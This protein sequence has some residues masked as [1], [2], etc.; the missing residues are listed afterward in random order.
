MKMS[1]LSIF[2]FIVRVT[3][4]ESPREDKKN[5]TFPD[6]EGF[7]CKEKQDIQIWLDCIIFFPFEM[8]FH[9]SYSFYK[10]E[11]Q[12]L[13]IFSQQAVIEGRRQNPPPP[14]PLRNGFDIDFRMAPNQFDFSTHQRIFVPGFMFSSNFEQFLCLTSGL[15]LFIIRKFAAAGVNIR[16]MLEFQFRSDHMGPCPLIHHYFGPMVTKKAKLQT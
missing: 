8:S 12:K 6:S 13:D 4:P 2:K 1:N 16:E 10:F 15:I 11:M 14:P 7:I 5:E 3:S 9:L